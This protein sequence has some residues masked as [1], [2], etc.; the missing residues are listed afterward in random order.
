MNLLN[1]ITTEKEVFTF[2]SISKPLKSGLFY[3]S[4]RFNGKVH[5]VNISIVIHN[6]RIFE[7][8]TC[9]PFVSITI[10]KKKFEF[11]Y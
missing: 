11:S 6:T 5:A 9:R 4:T 1:Y 8:W 7:F 10:F 3:T 2:N